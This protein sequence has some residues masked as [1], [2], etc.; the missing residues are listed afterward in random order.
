MY[1]F[2]PCLESLAKL[3]LQEPAQEPAQEPVQEPAQEPQEPT[4]K[5]K[6][7]FSFKKLFGIK[8]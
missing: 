3:S 5:P 4:P 2:L 6:S 1:V 7:K 8:H